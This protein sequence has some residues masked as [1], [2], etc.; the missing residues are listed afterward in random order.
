[1]SQFEARASFR[2][3]QAPPGPD[4]GRGREPFSS[5]QKPAES[6]KTTVE[7]EICEPFLLEEKL[8]LR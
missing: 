5:D 4:T 6:E 2:R 3:A 8:G 1:M 7:P